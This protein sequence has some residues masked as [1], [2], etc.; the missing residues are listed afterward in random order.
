MNQNPAPIPSWPAL[1]SLGDLAEWTHNHENQT[2]TKMKTKKPNI[3]KSKTEKQ[4]LLETYAARSPKTFMEFRFPPQH[5]D[6]TV[7]TS[8]YGG[9]VELKDGFTVQV[10]IDPAA[11]PSDVRDDLLEV[12]RELNR[13]EV[14]IKEMFKHILDEPEG[15]LPF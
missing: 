1:K 10:L 5:T 6:G 15:D 9:I 13:R 14:S 8:H 7:T 2:K 12:V 4:L 3:A 11:K